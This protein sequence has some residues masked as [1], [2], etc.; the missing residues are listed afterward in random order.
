MPQMHRR[1]L[2]TAGAAAAGLLATGAASTAPAHEKTPPGKPNFRYCLNFSTLRKPGKDGDWTLVEKIKFAADAGYQGIEPWI[3]EIQQH[4]AAGG[5][6]K[7]VKKLLDDSGLTVES[8]IGFARWI[9]DDEE[10]RKKGLED[11]RRDMDLVRQIGGARIAAPPIGATREKM[12]DYFTIAQRYR[13]LLQIGAKIGVTPQLEIWGPS[14]TLSRLGEAAFVA[15]ESSHPDACI[16][17][18]VY[19]I[20]RGGSDFAGLKMLAGKSVHVFHMNDYPDNPPRTEMNDSHRVYPGDGVAPLKN[21]LQMLADNGSTCA[22]SLEL[23]NR[24]Y[25]A[26]DPAQVARLGIAKMKAAVAQL[27]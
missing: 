6:L 4:V 11:A 12:T 27:G 20:F 1:Q 10:A 22:L 3:R 15:V 8:A 7:D 13:A 5:S 23:F 9:V 14:A 17:P 2:L 18:D 24:D 26:Q 19:H 25:W 16:L 21:I